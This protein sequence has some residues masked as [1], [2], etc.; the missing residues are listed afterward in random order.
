MKKQDTILIFFL[1][2]IITFSNAFSWKDIFHPEFN[3]APRFVGSAL[4][5]LDV[6]IE[7]A[8][9]KIGCL[10]DFNSDKLTDVFIINDNNTIDVYLWNHNIFKFDLLLEARITEEDVES[11][12]GGDFNYDGKLDLLLV[13]TRTNSSKT[14]S[15]YYGDTTKFDS[16]IDLDYNVSDQVS[17]IDY[18]GDLQLDLLA[19]DYDTNQTIVITNKHGVYGNETFPENL[20]LSKPNTNAFVDINGDCFSDLVVVVDVCS[21]DIC[22]KYMQVWL[23]DTKTGKFSHSDN[24]TY[25]LPNGVS[26]LTF[27]DFDGLGGSDVLF[28]VCEGKNCITQNYLAI[29]SNVQ[30]SLCGSPPCLKST[31]LCVADNSFYFGSFTTTVSTVN[32]II[33]Q[34]KDISCDEC[35]FQ[36]PISELFPLTLRYGDYNLDGFPDLIVPV[37]NEEGLRTVEL[38]R[39]E[40]C[41]VETCNG[42]SSR[43]TFVKE[44][45]GVGAMSKFENAY[46]ASFMDFNEDGILDILMFLEPNATDKQQMHALYNN[47]YNDAFF[48]KALGLN[49]VCPSWCSNGPKF[50]NPKPYGVNYVGS[51][52]KFVTTSL[53]GKKSIKQ[54]SAL[55]Q[56]SYFSLQ[57]PYI[58][59][60]LS[61][62]SN[63]VEYFYFGATVAQESGN[64]VQFIG[65]MP[66]SQLILIPYKA[67]NPLGWMMELYLNPS[68]Y[69]L[70]IFLAFFGLLLLTCAVIGFLKY[71]EKKEDVEE[72]KKKEILF[73]FSAL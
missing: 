64:S 8:T 16:K 51:T 49:G 21:N 32:T 19:T 30:M 52:F 68:S 34:M 18:D 5:D 1:L 17:I 60:G 27:A 7:N 50:P 38:W 72:G 58:L 56:N 3:H 25:E 59:F 66:S 46:A 73:S 10:G 40:A 29:V 2:F 69:I 26:Q 6:G 61:R 23:H 48:L 12:S 14:M 44:T 53:S 55:T 24:H 57:T 36:T 4:F 54:G 33:I 35:Y 67:N 62:T 45:T 43:R 71:R 13:K 22:K 37:S 39:N 9:G 15:I 42:I 41:T 11:I 70:W 20:N 47:F 31:N 28:A 65:I 63:Y